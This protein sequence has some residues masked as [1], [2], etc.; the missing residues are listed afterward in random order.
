M[1]S[2][3]P[4]A[5][6]APLTIPAARS[7]PT[8]PPSPTAT[9]AA[10]RA[11]AAGRRRLRVA[12][13][14]R[15]RRHGRR[16]PGPAAVGQP[17][18]RP[19]DDPGRPPGRRRPT[20]A[21]SGPRPRPPPTSTTRTSCPSTR[22]ASTTA[23]RSSPW[24]SSPAAASPTA[25]R[26]LAGRPATAAAALVAK[27]ARAVH[28]AHQRGILHRDLKPANV[29]LDADG[30]PQR[31]RLRPGQ[32]D[33]RATRGLTQSGAD[34][35]HARATWPRSRP[36]AGKAVTPAAD[37]YAL[38]AILYELLDRPAAVP[39]RVRPG[40]PAPGA[41]AGAGPPAAPSTRQADRDLAAVA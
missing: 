1:P 16:L 25:S 21:G 17:G 20:S 18:R 28:P 4:T 13:R 5:A 8:P 6:G 41:G 33:R 22:S 11:A 39:G 19:E 36:A 2:A 12:R 23:G 29:L 27:L 10:R 31:H 7:R 26:E 34:R 14:D 40:H 24:S 30:T 35:R 37:V 3:D 38:G 15:P 9:A 32:A